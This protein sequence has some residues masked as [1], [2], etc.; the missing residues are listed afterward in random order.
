L[1]TGWGL[2]DSRLPPIY[3]A[4]LSL[5]ADRYPASKLSPAKQKEN[6]IEALVSTVVGLSRSKPVLIVFE[7]AHWVDPTTLEALKAII[8]GVRLAAVLLT[9][10]CRPEFDLLW[11][12]RS[13]VALCELSR[14]SPDVS[15]DMIDTVTQGKALPDAVI[16]QIVAK[17]DGVPLFVEE[18]TKSVL[19]SRLLGRAADRY[20]FSGTG[21]GIE[22]P[23][24]L[25]AAS[26]DGRMIEVGARPLRN[27]LSEVFNR[28]IRTG[29][30]V[31]GHAAGVRRN[32]AGI[33]PAA[34]TFGWIGLFK[35]HIAF[36]RQKSICGHG[37]IF[38]VSDQLESVF[39]E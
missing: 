39:E 13:Q 5:P 15:A 30:C 34:C 23:A 35:F 31:H 38:L 27:V 3:A 11:S 29:N 25:K 32:S 6:T 24:T 26:I 7:D 18:V 16:Q 28:R 1:L 9:I 19:A 20:V 17:T 36:G 8:D 12:E 14:L 21:P 2:T 22:I 33:R 4:L 37:P 10:T